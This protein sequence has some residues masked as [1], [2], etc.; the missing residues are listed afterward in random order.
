MNTEALA[1]GLPN[2]MKRLEVPPS[3][4]PNSTSSFQVSASL[5]TSLCPKSEVFLV[6]FFFSNQAFYLP[7]GIVEDS[8]F[9]L[10]GRGGDPGQ[11]LLYL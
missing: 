3:M 5:N 9:V 8:D 1:E 10:Q 2:R 11:L 7:L 6:R 4:A